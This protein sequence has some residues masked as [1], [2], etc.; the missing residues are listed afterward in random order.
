MKLLDRYMSVS[1]SQV[2]FVH[3][4]SITTIEGDYTIYEDSELIVYSQNNRIN[5]VSKDI[6]DSGE[7]LIRSKVMD[8]VAV[9]L[10]EKL[11]EDYGKVISN[12]DVVNYSK[13]LSAL[14]RKGKSTINA[15]PDVLIEVVMPLILAS[16]LIITL[17]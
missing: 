9:F 16:S 2:H 11:G 3:N 4:Q 13:E 15:L 5:Y 1:M 17:L 8:R 10:E 7:L 6:M 14:I 12:D